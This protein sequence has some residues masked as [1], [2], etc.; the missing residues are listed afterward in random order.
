MSHKSK[1]ALA[2]TEEEKLRI[3]IP[4]PVKLVLTL[5]L[6]AALALLV[7]AC[8]G[9]SSSTGSS[10]SSSTEEA[11]SGSE[12]TGGAEPT[13][14]P[15]KILTDSAVNSPLGSWPGAV[16]AAKTA[17]IA[18]N[19]E[20]GIQGRPLEVIWCDSKLEPNA[21][22]A[23]ARKAVS[24]GAIAMTGVDS[25]GVAV[26]PILEKAGLPASKIPSQPNE[27]Q[28]P[29][30]FPL[31]GGGISNQV[32]APY[33]L[34]QIGVKEAS[35]AVIEFGFEPEIAEQAKKLAEHFGVKIVKT[36]TYAPTATTFDDV[37]ASLQEADAEGV[38]MIGSPVA[39]TGIIQAAAKIGYQP[40]AW[41]VAYGAYNAEL[42]KSTT[43][44]TS[45]VWGASSVPPANA[46]EQ[47]EAM[48]KFDE[49]SAVAAE[50]G[51]ES[52]DMNLRDE[53]SVVEWLTI[54]ALATLAN[55]IEGEVTAASMKK[56][57][58]TTEG[59]D[60][61]GLFTWE[62]AAEGLKTYPQLTDG[63][64]IYW[65]PFEGSFFKPE[66]DEP[67]RVLEEAGF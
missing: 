41:G 12:S 16:A 60:A 38:V 21:S 50:Q 35:M 32:G 3:Q 53:N 27:G 24:E 26:W 2:P 34:S 54:H 10:S 58:E 44:L 46:T 59:V 65:G 6:C 42:V 45:N 48:Q 7:A 23:C 9:S 17:A 37:A 14:K 40:K 66:N 33:A 30:N 47:F 49:E 31:T 57:L 29:I 5:A 15:I 22:A 25:N 8:G 64:G 36:V 18:V 56:Q 62:P 63:G 43:S 61:E 39:Q 52:T 19:E 13:G 28:V 4:S 20:G 51:V 67:V 11:S 55:E 1:W